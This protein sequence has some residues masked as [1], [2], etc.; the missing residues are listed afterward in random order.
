MRPKF[1]GDFT[2]KTF[3]SLVRPADCCLYQFGKRHIQTRGVSGRDTRRKA[4]LL[5]GSASLDPAGIHLFPQA[6]CLSGSVQPWNPKRFVHHDGTCAFRIK[7]THFPSDQ[8]SPANVKMIHGS[9]CILRY[10]AIPH[11]PLKSLAIP[12]TFYRE[13]VSE[14][15]PFVEP[16]M[17]QSPRGDKARSQDAQESLALSPPADLPDSERLRP[18][19][20]PPSGG[21][22]AASSN[23]FL[24][25]RSGIDFKEQPLQTQ[26]TQTSSGTIP[27]LHP[28]PWG[29]LE[30]GQLKI[31][32]SSLSR[33][34]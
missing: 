32:T 18:G 9:L 13:I 27:L 28:T 22:E 25:V 17:L 7:V 23:H 33:L 30:G 11:A 10:R 14:G 24:E 5:S 20:T 19:P 31:A 34:L 21:E 6:R 12:A 8:N 29:I 2:A 4:A 3:L 26:S 16:P 15:A 1:H